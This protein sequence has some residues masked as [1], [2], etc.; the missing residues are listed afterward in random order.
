MLNM[1]TTQNIRPTQ[2]ESIGPRRVGWSYVSHEPLPETLSLEIS[3][4]RHLRGS[5]DLT[6]KTQTMTF[7]INLKREICAKRIILSLDSG[8]MLLQVEGSNDT[9]ITPKVAEI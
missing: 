1:L 3:I 2:V 5:S 9:P 4:Q 7:T 8:K 6:G